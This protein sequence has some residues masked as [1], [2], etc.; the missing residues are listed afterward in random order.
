MVRSARMKVVWFGTVLDEKY[1]ECG[2]QS[3]KPHCRVRYDFEETSRPDLEE[4][5][6]NF[7]RGRNVDDRCDVGRHNR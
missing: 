1:V 6:S 4:I 3:T 2:L 7:L 5:I